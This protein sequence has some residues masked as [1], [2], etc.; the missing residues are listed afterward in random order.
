MYISE[1]VFT[2]RDLVKEIV[3]DGT[4]EDT[5]EPA[6][7]KSQFEKLYKSKFK[8]DIDFQIQSNKPVLLQIIELLNR[9][10]VFFDWNMDSFKKRLSEEFKPSKT[11][12]SAKNPLLE[13]L[14]NNIY[15]KLH[16]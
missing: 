16:E 5:L 7:V 9:E 10:G 13:K 14:A 4:I 11:S 12:L 15:Q 1:N 3:D 2:I 8:K 6:F